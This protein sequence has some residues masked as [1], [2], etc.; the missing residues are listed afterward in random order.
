MWPLERSAVLF[1]NRTWSWF[2]PD[3]LGSIPQ[4]VKMILQTSHLTSIMGDNRPY[5]TGFSNHNLKIFFK[6]YFFQ[7]IIEYNYLIVEAPP[8]RDDYALP[9]SVW[10]VHQVKYQWNQS[11]CNWREIHFS[12]IVFVR[13]QNNDFASLVARFIYVYIGTPVRGLFAKPTCW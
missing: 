6:R 4:V 5:F 2:V 9:L 1:P 11:F 13:W 3:V 10:D 8:A 7:L 12:W